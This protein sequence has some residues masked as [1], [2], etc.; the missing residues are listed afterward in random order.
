MTT[1][2][3]S[4]NLAMIRDS[5][6]TARVLNLALIHERHGDSDEYKSKPLLHTRLLNRAII[7]KHA[8]RINERDLFVNAPSTAT[9]III[10]F[11][12]SELQL[13]GR[14]LLFGER[15][16]ERTFHS[17]SGIDDPALLERDFEVLRLLNTLPSFDPYLMRERLRQNG[18]DP[19]R[20][21]FELSV[22]DVAQ[23]RAFVAREIGQLV[24]IALANGGGSARDLT[25]RLADKLMT[26]ESA[27]AL[28]PLRMALDLSEADYREGVF[29]WKGFLYYKWLY[30]QIE[31]RLESL[32]RKMLSVRVTDMDAEARAQLKDIRERIVGFM[33]IAAKKVSAT[34]MSYGLAFTT[35]IEGRPKE[36]RD[37]L[38]RA[39]E[40][41]I[42]IGEA[43]GVLQHIE[44]FWNY[45]FPPGS[46][47]LLTMDEAFEIFSDFDIT[48]ACMSVLQ[49]G[50]APGMQFLD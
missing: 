12:A 28:D 31:P 30:A 4:R 16:F 11:S 48:L 23:M 1:T 33:H 41:F 26:D 50:N 13:G 45:R 10:P 21:Y 24:N 8:V 3:G 6:S 38:L 19:A 46:P 15:S 17:L 39:P 32:A 47:P 7:L 22:A 42:P 36:F 14:S 2:K 9:K 29:S 44:T 25:T 18:L 5:G 37:F 20:C 49:G 35:L 34:L 27:K 40:L 43:V